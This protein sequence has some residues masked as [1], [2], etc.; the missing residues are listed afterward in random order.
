MFKVNTEIRQI[1]LQM[2]LDY[3]ETK[4]YEIHIQA[5]DK[6]GLSTH[7]KVE[8]WVE[9]VDDNV[10]EV[11]ITFHT[12]TFS[13]ATLLN[14]VVVFFRMQDQDLGHNGKTRCER[15]DEHFSISLLAGEAYVVVT[16]EALDQEEV[17]EYNMTV[18]ASHMG[19]PTLSALKTQPMWLLDINDNLLS[20][21]L[22]HC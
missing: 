7:C 15:L 9:D 4:T 3:E 21:C 16:L 6:E 11:A 18:W 14:K 19:S 17:S 12:K 22:H 13:K 10:P 2:P 8:V 5:T 20:D 1:R